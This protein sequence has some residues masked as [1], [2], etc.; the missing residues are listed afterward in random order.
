MV[1]KVTHL[2]KD[3]V[4]HVH[5]PF[6][7]QT[8]KL[9]FSR[10]SCTHHSETRAAWRA[11]GSVKSRV[12]ITHKRSNVL[13]AAHKPSPDAGMTPQGGRC[14]QLFVLLLFQDSACEILISERLSTPVSSVW[15]HLGWWAEPAL[16]THPR[17]RRT[18]FWHLSPLPWN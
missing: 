18:G 11:L 14:P 5:F 10:Y 13:P 6:T 16:P 9:L 17:L 4:Q 3:F 7:S 8:I 15:R 12:S 2:W 1:Y